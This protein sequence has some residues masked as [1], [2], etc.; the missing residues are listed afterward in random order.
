M[1]KK[2]KDTK[3]GRFI[4]G[5]LVSG[6]VKSIPFGVGS[7]L[8]NILDDVNGS[9]PGEFDKSTLKPQLI[10]IGFYIVLAILVLKGTI[11]IEEAE[12]VKGIID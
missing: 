7:L 12:S 4:T 11:S 2:F 3:F 1:K 6:V 8:S 9:A 5:K 10:K